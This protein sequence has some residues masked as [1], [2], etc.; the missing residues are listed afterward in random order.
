MIN[1]TKD[2]KPIPL[3]LAEAVKINCLYALYS[4]IALFW[5]QNGGDAIISML[6][7]NM[8]IY[9]RS[10]D[11][12]ELREFINIISPSSVFS[13][14]DTLT[15]LFGDGFHRV[16]VMKSEHRFKSDLKSDR[17]TSDQIYKLLD[18]DGL[19]LPVFEHFAVD[20]CHRL[21]HGGLKYFAHKNTCA[22]IAVFDPYSALI[23]GI[24]SHKKG[25]GSV[26]LNA[27]L[28]NFNVQTAIAVCEQDIKPF[29][30]KNH[31]YHSYYAGYWRKKA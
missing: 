1:L 6:D 3:C 31:F 27:L 26:A 5:Q 25:M 10:A 11:I 19:T 14:A 13:D 7:G 24:A 16:C 15:A 28:S 29:Y 12:D 4:D 23:N 21:N 18:V 2:L 20:F 22:A 9:N 30:I 17:L 8:T